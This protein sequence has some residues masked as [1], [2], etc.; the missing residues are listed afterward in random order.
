[1]PVTIFA[2]ADASWLSMG[3]EQRQTWQSNKKAFGDRL[4]SHVVPQ[5]RRFISEVQQGTD[6]VTE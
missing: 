5:T 1:M 4:R 3:E 6:Q 2:P